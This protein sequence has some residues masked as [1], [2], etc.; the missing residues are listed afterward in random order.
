M[1]GS[2]V[3]AHPST[4]E[5]KYLSLREFQ[6]RGYLQELNRQFLHPL[7]LALEVLFG[8]EERDD[9]IVG[10][11]DDRDDPEGNLFHP[12][13]LDAEFVRKARTVAAEIASK[14]AERLARF[15]FHIQPVPEEIG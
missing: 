1:I 7:G 5:V 8:E 12:D 2:E 15:G 4:P 3:I 13:A 6:G 11:W 14:K 9:R 10:V